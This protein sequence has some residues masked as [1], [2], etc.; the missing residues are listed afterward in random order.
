MGRGRRKCCANLHAVN[1]VI[2]TYGLYSMLEKNPDPL[3]R[4]GGG[5]G[6]G[7]HNFKKGREPPPPP[8]VG[9]PGHQKK[10]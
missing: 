4:G 8:W 3:R 10:A 1:H 2:I 6:E 9:H 5:A 7:T